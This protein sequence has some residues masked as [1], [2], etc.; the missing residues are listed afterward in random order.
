MN[1]LEKLTPKP[2]DVDLTLTQGDA[3]VQQ[4]TVTIV[5]PTYFE[6]EEIEASVETPA[7]PL[8]RI[9]G[10]K[11]FP[12]QAD[13][14]YKV[15]VDAAQKDRQLRLVAFALLNGGNEIGPYRPR[16][17]RSGQ[18]DMDALGEA[19]HLLATAAQGGFIIGLYG[20]MLAALNMKAQRREVADR[21]D[22]FH[23]LQDGGDA[24]RV[25]DGADAKSMAE[26]AG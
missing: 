23:G 19:A 3:V 11:K 26:P 10:G 12:N 18:I 20:F 4:V 9:E 16:S 13:P 24:D 2:I 6:W 21:A 15:A 8:T 5:L 17:E 14:D 1:I 22:R 25:A 7:I